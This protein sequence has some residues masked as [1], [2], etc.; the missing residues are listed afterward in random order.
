[1]K[2]AIGINRNRLDGLWRA[3][4]LVGRP[5][6]VVRRPDHRSKRTPNPYVRLDRPTRRSP[7]KSGSRTTAGFRALM[8]E[9]SLAQRVDAVIEAHQY[10][11]AKCLRAKY[12]MNDSDEYSK[13]ITFCYNCCFL[14]ALIAQPRS[15]SPASHAPSRDQARSHHREKGDSPASPSKRNANPRASARASGA[16]GVRGTR[17]QDGNVGERQR[18]LP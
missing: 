18:P 16:P 8:S 9:L 11:P 12:R 13:C 4:G 6:R 15:S 14:Y 5:Q 1:M 2:D 10:L 7:Q 17:Q 3:A